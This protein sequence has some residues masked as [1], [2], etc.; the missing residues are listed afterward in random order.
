MYRLIAS[1][2]LLLSIALPTS[3][4]CVAGYFR[5]DGTYVQGYCR[6]TPN[7]NRYDNYS[8]QSMGG[9]QRDEFSSSPSYNK[10]SPSYSFGDNDRDGLLN[11]YDPKPESKCNYAFGQDGC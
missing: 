4:D 6:S 1:G 10:T 2:A 8:S 11:R 5:K 9:K 3:A 7:Q